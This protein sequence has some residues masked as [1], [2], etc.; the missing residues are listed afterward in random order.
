MDNKRT[1]RESGFELLRIIC[2][3]FV[4]MQHFLGH[5]LYPELQSSNDTTSPVTTFMTLGFLYV[6][7]LL[8]VDIGLFQNKN[9]LLQTY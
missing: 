1:N 7:V 8:R 6:A 2:M 3:L 9:Q 4:V 5:A